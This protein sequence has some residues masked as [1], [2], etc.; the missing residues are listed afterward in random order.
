MNYTQRDVLTAQLI[1]WVLQGTANSFR[2]LRVKQDAA[3][4]KKSGK[5]RVNN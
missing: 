1:W 4:K 2:R 5:G 3:R